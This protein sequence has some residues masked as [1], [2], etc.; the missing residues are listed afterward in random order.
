VLDVLL[1]EVLPA[2]E[3]RLM[4]GSNVTLDQVRRVL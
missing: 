1:T 4:F 2:L 3:A